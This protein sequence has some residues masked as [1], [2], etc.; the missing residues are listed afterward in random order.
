MSLPAR[1]LR[2]DNDGVDKSIIPHWGAISGELK[3]RPQWVVYKLEQRDG[4]QT[5]VPY[6]AR[7]PK[8][9]AQADNPITWGTFE[10]AVAAVEAGQ[11]EGIGFVFSE[12]DPY[13]GIDLDKCIDA[14][15]GEIE[16]W[17]FDIFKKFNTYAERSQ[18]GTGLHLIGKGKL[19]P[20]G[21]R[22]GT[23]EMYDSGR[24]FVM[25]GDV[26]GP[27]QPIRNR[28]EQLD[29][30]H[31]QTFGKAEPVA[32]TSRPAG[33]LQLDD[34][35][36]INKAIS[37]KNGAAFARLWLGDTAGYTSQSEADL[38]LCSKLYFWTGGD[39]ARVDSL[40]RQSRLMRPKWDEMRGAMTYGQ[41][42]ILEAVA[43]GGD[44]YTPR[45]TVESASNS[46]NTVVDE[47]EMMQRGSASKNHNTASNSKNAVSNDL[48]L[49]QSPLHQK[50]KWG[51]TKR[52]R[53][54]EWAVYHLLQD[55][56]ENSLGGEPGVG[57][58][59]I[60]AE[61]AVSIAT[62]TPFLGRRTKQGPV[63]FINFDDSEALPRTWAERACR[64]RGYEFDDLPI[65]YWEPDPDKEYPP[66]GLLTG[67]VFD[68]LKEAA[69]EIQPRLIIVDAFSTAFP[70][71]DGNKAQDVVE[72]FEKLRQLRTAAG[73]A[74][75]LLVDHTPKPVML[76]SKRRGISGSQQKHA[77]TRSVHIVSKIEPAQVNG[78]DV[79]EWHVHKMNAAPYQAPFAV[80]RHVD[81]QRN[82]AWFEVDKLPEQE[83]APKENRAAEVA[84]LIIQS[85]AGKQVE[86]QELIGEVASK[87]NIGG[88]TIIKAIAE[89]VE[90]HPNVIVGTL[91]GRG[92][93]KAYRWHGVT[94]D[95]SQDDLMQEDVLMQTPLH[96]N[97]SVLDDKKSFDELM[98]LVIEEEAID[99]GTL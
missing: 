88:R 33:T 94:P 58:S 9:R 92:N 18:S 27:L 16:P 6:Q 46:R 39:S 74:C 69:T 79:L 72:V 65:Y 87:T 62:G 55:N 23:L 78:A 51:Q 42:T 20:A 50:L 96:Q 43:G 13:F 68:F 70:G 77:R 89:E 14:T 28:Q 48:D 73:G 93:P 56:A 71:K 67:Y 8:T 76:E 31:A 99:E 57:K 84:L 40:F 64:A 61:L 53:T 30:L 91:P 75:M 4:K 54:P 59:W 11:A 85:R 49:M 86:R 35:E 3:L 10:Q 60:T 2:A 98:Q 47:V 41:T 81:T 32:P 44:V 90:G 95:D 38:A 34:Q 24:F 1:A 19:P 21:R 97:E 82:T 22:K 7:D 5:K 63:M 37:S 15:T 12:S 36:L 25:T 80:K 29:E 52:P 17:A 66:A 45:D 26:Y 83:R